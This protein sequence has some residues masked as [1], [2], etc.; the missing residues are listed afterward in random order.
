MNARF[1]TLTVTSS[2]VL[3]LTGD[4]A[5]TPPPLRLHAAFAGS[6]DAVELSFENTSDAP[7]TI[8]LDARLAEVQLLDGHRRLGRCRVPAG[9][10]SGAPDERRFV[11]IA[12]GGHVSERL[13]L[14]FTCFG[15]LLE[16]LERAGTIE[17]SYRARFG[18]TPLGER[19]WTGSLGPV[20]LVP[21]AAVTA[22]VEDVAGVAP[23]AAPAPT[24]HHVGPLPDVGRGD[25]VAVALELRGPDQ[26]R[27]RVAVR[28]E[29]F[30]FLIAAPDGSVA[31]C[32]LPLTGVRTL[33]EFFEPLGRRRVA[34]DLAGICPDHTFDSAGIYEITPAFDNTP[35]ADSAVV[36]A[37]TGSVTGRPFLLRVRRA[38][39][40]E[41][42][43]VNMSR[44]RSEPERGG[45]D[46]R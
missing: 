37:W 26:A 30:Q 3:A 43:L 14:R 35:D 22:P 7:V 27:V 42:D 24:L 46:A 32:R 21:P 41:A 45:I 12:P 40:I 20:S 13:D 23:A 8:Y 9:G 11:S 10:M 6:R 31:A 25:T 5:A 36:H 16:P 33:P 34:L 44:T 28:P 18:R 2:L 17:V 39:E 15:R 38:G 19:S 1:T 4:T 29:Y